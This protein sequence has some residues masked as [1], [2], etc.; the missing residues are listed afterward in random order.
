MLFRSILCLTRNPVPKNLVPLRHQISLQ[1][2]GV[3][4]MQDII[5]RVMS[6][7]ICILVISI[8]GW[9]WLCGWKR[10]M[11]G[12]DITCWGW[13]CGGSGS[14]WTAR[15]RRVV[16]SVRVRDWGEEFWSMERRG[17]VFWENGWGGDLWSYRGGREEGRLWWFGCE[18]KGW[19]ARFRSPQWINESTKWYSS[20]SIHNAP[21]DS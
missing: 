8:A 1:Y 16:P 9:F 3:W 15:T 13:N 21:S 4:F 17:R 10:D 6:T 20:L 7:N 19:V 11:G 14:S 5:G 18:N 12:V 2:I